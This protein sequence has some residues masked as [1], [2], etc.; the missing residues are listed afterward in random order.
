MDSVQVYNCSQKD[1]YFA[2]IRWEGAIGGH[3][4]V[5]NSAIHNGRDWAVM[6]WKSNNVELIDNT[7]V[8]FR[9]VGMN[10]DMVRNC[11]ITGNFIGDIVSRNLPFIDHTVDKEACVAH[12]T[13]VNNGPGNPSYDMIFMDNIAAGCKFAGFMAPAHK[14]GDDDQKSFRNN[15]AHSVDGYGIYMYANPA[16][17]S[18]NSKCVELSHMTSYKVKETCVLAYP[19]T[20]ELRAHHINCIDNEKGV[21]L[22]TG[23]KERDEV[24]IYFYD[25]VIMGGTNALDCP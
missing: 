19:S 8:G 11:T 10:L 4:R 12:G 18:T 2:A 25:S 22:I 3:S 7:F 16:L 17:S 1:M 13:Y 5:S 9:A 15:I 14:C 6:I 21:S 23:G 20:E 24:N